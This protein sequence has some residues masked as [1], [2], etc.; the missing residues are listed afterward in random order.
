MR[1]VSQ[2]VQHVGIIAWWKKRDIKKR[3]RSTA[4]TKTN[5]AIIPVAFPYIEPLTVKSRAKHTPETVDAGSGQPLLQRLGSHISPARVHSPPMQ[6]FEGF[7]HSGLEGWIDV[8][9][10]NSSVT[11]CKVNTRNKHHRYFCITLQNTHPVVT[12][13]TPS[14]ERPP[15]LEPERKLHDRIY[16]AH[17][18]YVLC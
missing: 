18:T 7:V 13:A 11:F 4:R 16:P 9:K 1:V 6:G 8:D 15:P 2:P 14:R 17:G 5:I 10:M 3:D 12:D